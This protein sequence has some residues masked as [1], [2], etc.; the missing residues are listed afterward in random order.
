MPIPLKLHQSAKLENDKRGMDYVPKE[1]SD[2]D[3]ENE[4]NDEDQKCR[5]DSAKYNLEMASFVGP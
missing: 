4:A 2:P 3:D 5:T 1:T